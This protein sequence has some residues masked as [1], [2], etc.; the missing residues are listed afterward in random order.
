VSVPGDHLLA[1]I[2]EACEK[3]YRE[4]SQAVSAGHVPVFLGGDHSLAMGTVGGVSHNRRCG[5][6]W[7]DAHGDFNTPETTTTGNVHG[8]PLAAL[9]GRGDPEL[10]GLGRAGPKV[11][12]SDVVVVG[13]RQLDPRE[14][15]MLKSSGMGLYTMR[16]I[17]ERGM[18][19]VLQEALDQLEPLASYHVSL[20]M[21]AIDPFEAP[22]VGTPVRGGLTYREA[23]LLME[24]IADTGKLGSMDVVE[25]NP[26][27]DHENRTAQMAVGLV[28]S[29]LGKRIL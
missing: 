28:A 15:Q 24:I 13:L 10:T 18:S 11:H 9:L 25:I 2:R 7:I 23:Q 26:V 19:A 21:D 1:T 12:P 22:G 16:D 8:M 29:A 3:A 5:L 14:R 27:L 6:V 20:D 4:A 17:D